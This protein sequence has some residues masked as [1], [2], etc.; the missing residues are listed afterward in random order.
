MNA[1]IKQPG[2]PG[3]F[4]PVN[5]NPPGLPT[6]PG[7][8]VASI[9]DPKRRGELYPLYHQLRRVA[10]LQKNRP[11]VLHGTWTACR[12]DHID[13][14][15]RAT[16]VVNDPRV[17]DSAF[18]HGDGGFTTVMRNVLTWQPV[19]PHMRMRNQIMS[20]FT[21]RAISR[22]RPIADQV[23]NELCD[24]LEGMD[25][26][27]LVAEYNYRIPFLIIARILGIPDEDHPQIEK[28][29]WDFARG[30]ETGGVDAGLAARADDAAR[31][32]M[33]YF[34]EL[35]ERRRV[36]RG[37]DLISSLVAATADKDLMTQI[38][39]VCNCIY[40]LQAGHETTQDLLG[41][42]QV[43]LFRQPDQLDLLRARPDLTEN[44]VEEF[45]RYDSSVQISHRIGLQDIELDGQTIPQ[46]ELL[47]IFNGA[48]NR[49][50]AG[51]PDPDR[52]DITRRIPH[53]LAFTAGAYYCIGAALARTEIHAGM[54]ALVDRFP[55]L[56]PSTGEF[57]WRTTLTLRGPQKLM[58]T[59]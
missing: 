11:D 57:E 40:L 16:S 42:A 39:L 33:G 23:A 27:D 50:P 30:G 9:V 38:E 35:I 12:F 36:E 53:H 28:F 22:W 55:H 4:E 45:L 6:D 17:L 3:T 52:L 2:I 43:A 21:P 37:E 46:G 54:R 47:Y 32:L 14:L 34:A 24:R 48:A 20:A 44:A 19:E 10:P 8:I 29:A 5:W 15:Y 1:A 58:A 59:W 51:F 41:N 56:R 7:E 26:A 18:N 13:H 49:D 31:G 25:E